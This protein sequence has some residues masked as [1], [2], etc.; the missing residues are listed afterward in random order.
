MSKFR[1]FLP[2]LG[3]SLVLAAPSIRAQ[4]PPAPAANPA[5]PQTPPDYGVG[6]KDLLE[7]R[8]LELPELNVERRVTDGGT[9]DLPMLGDFSVSGLSASQVRDKLEKMLTEKYVN[10][11]NVSVVI[12]E[13]GNKPLAVLGAVQKPGSL[14]ISGAWTLL[15]AI[16]AAGGLT[17]RAGKTIYVLR[18]AE[19]GLSDTLEINV[20]DLLHSSATQWN[21]PLQPGDIVNVEAKRTIRVFCLGAV[22]SPGALEFDGDDRITLLTVIARAGGLTDKAASKV[23]VKRRASD[24]K[25]SEIVINFGRVVS[26]KDPD[27]KL[28]ADDV[29]I[30]KESFF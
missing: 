26:G 20:D 3:L 24:G 14:N 28:Q 18:R 6:P 8:V 19:N 30:V 2:I 15:Q 1:R 7:I 9:I 11:A 10:H 5:P 4:Q 12:K 29:V 16:S 25:D 17:E 23:R 13:F 22:K 27:P 21:V